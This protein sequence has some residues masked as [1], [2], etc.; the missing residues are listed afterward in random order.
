MA[1][2]SLFAPGETSCTEVACLAT[3]TYLLVVIT[4]NDML[5][6]I[7]S[8]TTMSF[9]SSCGRQM[10]KGIS[11]SDTGEINQSFTSEAQRRR[12]GTCNYI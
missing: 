11:S 7:M 8:V 12:S 3:I 6:L 10:V 2:L 5:K 4:I 9:C 1:P